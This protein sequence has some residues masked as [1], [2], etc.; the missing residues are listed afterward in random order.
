MKQ[1]LFFDEGQ[2]WSLP[3]T[4]VIGRPIEPDDPMITGNSGFT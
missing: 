2:G 4:I 3:I 1:F